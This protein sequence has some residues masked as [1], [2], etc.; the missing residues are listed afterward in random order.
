MSEQN[1]TLVYVHDPM[2]SWCWGFRPAFTQLVER[3]PHE[4]KVRYLLGGLAPDSS[5]P[6]PA[7]MRAQLEAT[8]RRI[9]AT[10]PGTEFNFDFWRRAS[11]RRSTWPACRAVLATRQL[12]PNKEEEMI[13]AI[14]TA[15]YRQARNPSDDEVLT[16]LAGQIG[17]DTQAFAALLH[18]TQTRD[19]L[20][21][22][23]ATARDLGVTGFPDLRLAVG[24]DISPVPLDYLNHEPMLQ[25]I[26]QQLAT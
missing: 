14:Q 8:W 22:E 3:L 12:D 6:M 2:C 7:A 16:A 13:L 23:I 4:L 25:S 10:I 18:A 15:Y 1:A 20:A 21:Q 11:P 5:A 9:Q 24:K 17:L 26:L 19:A